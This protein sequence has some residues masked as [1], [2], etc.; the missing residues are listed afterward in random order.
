M[1]GWPGDAVMLRCDD[2]AAARHAEHPARFGT[3]TV[4]A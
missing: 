3:D 1:H 4:H 2:A